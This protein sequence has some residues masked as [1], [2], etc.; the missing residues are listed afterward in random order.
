MDKNYSVDHA[1]N[2]E[3][4]IFIIVVLVSVE[5]STPQGAI[6]IFDINLLI[7]SITITSAFILRRDKEK[8]HYKERDWVL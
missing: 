1:G 6:P 3:E 7:I 4:V 8:T 2:V 5:E